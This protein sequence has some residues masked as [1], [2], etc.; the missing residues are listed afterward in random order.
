MAARLA[1]PALFLQCRTS[2]EVAKQRIAARTGD[3]SD[4]DATTYDRA[5]VRWQLFGANTQ[6]VVR[7]VNADGTPD[8]MLDQALAAF[9][10]IPVIDP[11]Q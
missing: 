8:A 6:R 9:G 7:E 2:P 1:I 4:A 3:A 5:A 11:E 10:T